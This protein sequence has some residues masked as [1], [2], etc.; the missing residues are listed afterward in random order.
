MP[1]PSDVPGEEGRRERGRGRGPE[2]D[3]GGLFHPETPAEK[4]KQPGTGRGS[5][6]DSVGGGP[7]TEKTPSERDPVMQAAV[8]RLQQAIQRIENRRNRRMTGP[9][10]AVED[11]ANMKRY[12]D[13]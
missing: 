5:Q 13:W 9:A 2:P 4:Q 11:P 8:L 12:R 6:G 10:P 7:S 3:V 1:A